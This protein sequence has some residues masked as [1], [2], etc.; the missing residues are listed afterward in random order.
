MDFNQNNREVESNSS[1]RA[2]ARHQLE[3]NWTIPVV[4]ALTYFIITIVIDA[5]PIPGTEYDMTRYFAMLF[6]TE[7]YEGINN[8]ATFKLPILSLLFSGALGIGISHFHLTFAKNG[9]ADL[10]LIF[11]GFKQFLQSIIAGV[12]IGIIVIIGSLL[13]I[14]PGVIASLGLSQ[15]YYIM[16]D[17]PGISA[18]DAMQQ[19]WDMTKGYKL[20]LFILGLSFIP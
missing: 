20:Q 18:I 14:I 11:D 4:T 16:S 9:E 19:S 3:G 5:I 12:L 13:F 15:T 7:L 6:D 8:E 17:N 2:M 1:I 10:P